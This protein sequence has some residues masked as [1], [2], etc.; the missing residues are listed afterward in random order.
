MRGT[1]SA[2]YFY[3]KPV[4]GGKVQLEGYTFDVQRTVAVKIDGK[5]DEQGNYSFEFDLPK[6]LTGS[7]LNKGSGRF[8]LQAAVTDLA[9]HT[10]QVDT[11]LPVS[12]S[13]LVIDAIPEGGYFR[14]NV[15]NIFY[16]QVS[17]PDGSPAEA[18]LKLT[19]PNDGNQKVDAAT[20]TYGLAE[21]R[22]TPR[23]PYQTVQIEARDK[24]GNVTT[25][26]FNFQGQSSEETVLLRPER[27]VYK[28]GEPMKLTLLTSKPTGTV[29]LDIVR[30]GQVVSTR[31]VEMQ[32]G[33]AQVVVD[34]TPDLFGT[35]ELHAYKLLQSGRSPCATRAW[36]WSTRP[37]ASRWR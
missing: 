28:V 33:Q 1:L 18:T 22:R 9:E 14:P 34:L 32:A 8:Y 16:V 7:E 37:E 23:H 11:S 20:G 29:Y 6:Y 36:W 26:Q 10:E 13:P 4:A 19:F 30:E 15:E 25:R 5:T 17:Y 35:L 27:P 24:K 2:N 21:V 12:S 3:G 31:A